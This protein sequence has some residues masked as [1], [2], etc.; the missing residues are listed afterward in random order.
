[1][2]IYGRLVATF[3]N[4]QSSRYDEDMEPSMLKSNG[5]LLII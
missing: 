2:S 4:Y 5:H 1:M 3:A